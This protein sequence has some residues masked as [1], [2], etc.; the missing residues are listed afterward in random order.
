MFSGLMTGG[1]P[2]MTATEGRVVVGARVVA[3]VVLGSGVAET[4]V[5]AAVE[6]I[7]DGVGFLL[8]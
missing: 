2:G 4:D 5:V 6:A 1:I 7:T 8:G 3:T